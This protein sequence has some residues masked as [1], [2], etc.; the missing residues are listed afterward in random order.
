MFRMCYGCCV[1]ISHLCYQCSEVLPCMLIWWL[2]VFN[3][4]WSNLSIFPFVVNTALF[5]P[6]KTKTSLFQ[7]HEDTLLHCLM[8]VLASPVIFT[9]YRGFFFIMWWGKDHFFPFF[10]WISSC[11]STICEK[12]VLFIT[13]KIIFD[14]N[15]VYQPI[16]VIHRC[17]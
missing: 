4:V 2:E 6:L 13:C 11:F 14:I 10:I 1:F 3:S 15:Q 7:M 9:T 16:S 8:K 5:L 17:M 12:T